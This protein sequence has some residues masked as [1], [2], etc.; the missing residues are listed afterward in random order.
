MGKKQI[1]ARVGMTFVVDE[2]AFL[3]NPEKELARA[4][5]EEKLSVDGHSYVP[6]SV[7]EDYGFDIDYDVEV[8]I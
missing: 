2:D 8:E 6:E 1:W 4:L 5:R 7:L 3:D